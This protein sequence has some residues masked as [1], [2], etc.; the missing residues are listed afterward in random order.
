MRTLAFGIVLASLLAALAAQRLTAP[1]LP[2]SDSPPTTAAPQPTPPAKPMLTTPG[3]LAID[4]AP[5]GHFYADGTVNGTAL[6]F[7]VDTGASTVALGRDEARRLGLFVADGDFTATAL[8]AGGT[9]RVA[10]VTI[11]RMT[12]GPITATDVAGSVVDTPTLP[13]LLG[14]S[15]LSNLRDVTIRENR[16]EL[17]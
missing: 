11:P 8:T 12:V 4:R 5:D 2:T 13:P 10:P 17:R 9:V 15:F 3:A 14:Q 1:P 6:R 16:M 7:L